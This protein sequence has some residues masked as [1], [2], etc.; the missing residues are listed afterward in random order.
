MA[1]EVFTTL[2]GLLCTILSSVVTFL[3]TKKKYATEV[4]AQQIENISHS[5]TVH[6]E[7]MEKT[8]ALQNQK[9]EALEKENKDLKEQ[10]HHLQMQM[11]NLMKDR[12][13]GFDYEGETK[14]IK[15]KKDK[16]DE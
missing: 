16:K 14:V 8:I 1:S 2:I 7:I 12:I 13:E 5:F 15:D 6:T 3:L 4:E 11:F 10:V 9:I